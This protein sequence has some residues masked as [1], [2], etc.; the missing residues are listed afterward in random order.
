MKTLIKVNKFGKKLPTG[1]TPEMRRFSGKT[2]TCHRIPIG[3]I[4]LHIDAKKKTFFFYQ[5]HVKELS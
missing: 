2:L 4:Y 5:S 3:Y 1:I